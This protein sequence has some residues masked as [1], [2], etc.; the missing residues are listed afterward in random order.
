[1][2]A[3]TGGAANDASYVLRVTYAGHSVLLAAD[4]EGSGWDAMLNRQTNLHADVFKLPHHGGWPS[5]GLG[6]E[7]LLNLVKARYVVLSVGSTNPYQHPATRT[8][9]VLRSHAIT[10]QMRFLCTQATPQCHRNGPLPAAEAISILCSDGDEV[11]AR[12]AGWCP[13]AGTV[14]AIL[15]RS[16][17]TLFPTV[18]AHDQVIDLFS[19]P[20]CR[21]QLGM[22]AAASE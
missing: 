20:Q 4:V 15:N 10:R 2:L 8:L 16:A 22:S 19:T 11:V 1:M 17:V 7:D 12:K 6:V 21:A 14:T 3:S 18:A 5:T 13:C 9:A